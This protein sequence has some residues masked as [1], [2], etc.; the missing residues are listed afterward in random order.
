MQKEITRL[1]SCQANTFPQDLKG[2]KW[3][4]RGKYCVHLRLENQE[5]A[6]T[7][8]VSLPARGNLSRVGTALESTALASARAKTSFWKF[9]KQ[10]GVTAFPASI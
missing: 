7:P 1:S 5:R 10:S 4:A 2:A 6:E 3:T 8:E 9:G